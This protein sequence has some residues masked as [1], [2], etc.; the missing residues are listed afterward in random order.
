M[1]YDYI[2]FDLDGTLTDPGIGITNSVMYALKKYGIEVKNRRELYR[3][4][5]PPLTDS[6]VDFYGFSGEEAEKAV[7]YYREYY[8]DRGIFEN[9]IYPGAE[10]LLK[11]LKDAGKTLMVATSKPEVFAKQ[12]LKYFGISNYF[13][14]VAGSNIDGTRV[15]KAEVI[16]YALKRCGVTE[17]NKAIMIGDREHDVF[18][19]KEAGISSVGVLFGYGDRSELRNAGADFIAERYS[20]IEKIVLG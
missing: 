14:I 19:A 15:K 1:K 10:H 18:G 11:K 8:K 17:L 6:F 3:F 12:I 13:S 2:L 9:S 16:G 5:G 7:E 20:D 4:I